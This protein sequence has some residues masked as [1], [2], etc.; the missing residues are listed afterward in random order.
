MQQPA[1]ERERHIRNRRCSLSEAPSCDTLRDKFLC[2]QAEAE[3]KAEGLREDLAKSISTCRM[4]EENYQ[5]QLGALADHLANA[6]VALAEATEREIRT[7]EQSRQKAKAVTELEA[8]SKRGADVCDQSLRGLAMQMCGVRQIRGDLYKMSNQRP[9]IQD[10]QVSD[11][12]PNECTATCGGGTQV[13]KRTVIAPAELGAECPELELTRECGAQACPEDCA[14]E[15]WSGWDACSSSMK[16]F[17]G[18][19]ERYRNIKQRAKHR[20]TP[21]EQTVEQVSC[22]AEACDQ[23]CKLF[24]WSAWSNC[25]KACDGGFEMRERR[26]RVDSLGEGQCPAEDN[27]QRLEY[28]RCNLDQCTPKNGETLQ[29]ASKLDVVLLLDGSGSLG[30]EGFEEMKKAGAALARAFKTGEEYAQVGVLLF[31]GP[32]TIEKYHTCRNGTADLASDCRI[33]WVSRF[34]TDMS[35]LAGMIENLKWPKGPALTSS[36]LAVAESELIYGRPGAESI[37]ITLTDG[38]TMDPRKTTSTAKRLRKRARLLWVPVTHGHSVSLVKQ[39]AS[40]PKRDNV[41]VLDSLSDLSATATINHII[42]D[43]CPQ[44]E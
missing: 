30:E 40:K 16:C 25:S 12:T 9:F 22:N 37:L 24:E 14:L 10:C 7:Q 5:A 23:E 31:S 28:R 6:Q 38:K 39:W 3:D 13:L 19:K 20:G 43:A 4:T 29:C 32:P 15:E 2:M 1:A 8:E 41:L 33:Q 18:V 11:W 17:P 34:T 42:A 35:T 27:E 21:C 36:A 44:V 26:I